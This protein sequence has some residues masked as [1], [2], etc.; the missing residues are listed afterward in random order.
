MRALLQNLT[1]RGL[2]SI[3][4]IVNNSFLLHKDCNPS[5]VPTRRQL[6]LDRHCLLRP[7]RSNTYSK[8]QHMVRV[9]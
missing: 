4:N 9:M 5:M 2:L 1:Y 6:Q 7:V 8:L 3:V